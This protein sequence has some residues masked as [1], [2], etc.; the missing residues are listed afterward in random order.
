MY[1]LSIYN[2]NAEH[3]CNFEKIGFDNVNIDFNRVHVY[4]K[5][6]IPQLDVLL[7]VVNCGFP[8]TKEEFSSF[9][10]KIIDLSFGGYFD[11][12]RTSALEF[13]EIVD[14]YPTMTTYFEELLQGQ[15]FGVIKDS[16]GIYEQPTGIMFSSDKDFANSVDLKNKAICKCFVECVAKE[17]ESKIDI[18]EMFRLS[19]NLDYSCRPTKQ[20]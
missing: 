11:L 20:M 5:A 10:L 3:K 1:S 4:I 15:H 12:N 19:E 14:K 2:F 13:K 6:R 8:K 9:A 17:I 18:I 16:E 7:E